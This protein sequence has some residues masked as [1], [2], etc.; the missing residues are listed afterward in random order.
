MF[1][2]WIKN[3]WRS[4]NQ[5]VDDQSIKVFLQK[6]EVHIKHLMVLQEQ[7]TISC[8]SVW[9][10][11]I[12]WVYKQA[13]W[14]GSVGQVFKITF[15]YIVDETLKVHDQS[16]SRTAKDNLFSLSHTLLSE[17]VTDSVCNKLYI[18]LCL[19]NMFENSV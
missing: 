13:D 14:L 8:S 1:G 19:P 15:T 6:L 16:C 11:K 9:K 18:V 12:G 4:V 7:P 2:A 17:P 3:K 5:G 10:K